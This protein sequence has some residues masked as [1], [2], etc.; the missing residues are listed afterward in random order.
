MSTFLKKG[1]RA[2]FLSP[3]RSF[4]SICPL[5]VRVLFCNDLW[6]EELESFVLTRGENIK[7]DLTSFVFQ[8][9]K[10]VFVYLQEVRKEAILNTSCS[11]KD[12]KELER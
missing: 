7:A 11:F 3:N 8:S 6:H 4:F 12:A 10:E 5:K 2:A 9:F 1:R